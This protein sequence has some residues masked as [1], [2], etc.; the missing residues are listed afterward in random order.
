MANALWAGM[1]RVVFGATIADAN[2]FC[3]QILVPAL[4][5]SQRSDMPCEVVGEVERELC[6]SLFHDPRMVEAFK[7]WGTRKA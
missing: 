3:R 2:E 1:D 6:R 7:S 5:V 4:E